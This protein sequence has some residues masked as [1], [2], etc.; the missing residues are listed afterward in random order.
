VYVF[1]SQ[2]VWK[3]LESMLTNCPTVVSSSYVRGTNFYKLF[4]VHTKLIYCQLNFILFYFD[5]HCKTINL[6]SQDSW[7][8][9]APKK[10]LYIH[11]IIASVDASKQWRSRLFL[12]HFVSILWNVSLYLANLVHKDCMAIFRKFSCESQFPLASIAFFYG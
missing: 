2:P 4:F 8:I 9:V 5:N 10:N 3:R 12:R 7:I 11:S 6:V 1:C